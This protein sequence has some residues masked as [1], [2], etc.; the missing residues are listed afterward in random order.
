MD[1]ALPK[2]TRANPTV[3][4]SPLMPFIVRT[5]VFASSTDRPGA[6]A[7]CQPWKNPADNPVATRATRRAA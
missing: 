5:K 2:N 3:R 1:A 7:T 6:I 4:I